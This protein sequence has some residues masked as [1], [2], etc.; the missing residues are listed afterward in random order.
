MT[1][2][3]SLVEYKRGDSSKPKPRSKGNHAK[4]GGD[5]GSRGYT[6]KEGSSK[7]SSGKDGVAKMVRAKTNRRSS[8]PGPIASY[9]MGHTK[10]ETAPIGEP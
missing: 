4:C 2:V 3:E 6:P 8:H 5:K 7:T 10:R 9:V 1:V